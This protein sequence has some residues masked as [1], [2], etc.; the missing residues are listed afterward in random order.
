MTLHYE[1]EPSDPRVQ[2]ALTLVVDEFGNVLKSAAIGYGRRRNS[3]DPAFTDED[4]AKQRLIH[5]TATE[6]TYTNAI[7]DTDGNYRTPLP[8]ESATYELRKPEQERSPDGLTELYRFEDVLARV[9]QAGDG[10]HEVDYEERRVP[11]A[12]E[13]IV[14]WPGRRHHVSRSVLQDRPDEAWQR[15]EL[16]LKPHLVIADSEHLSHR[17]QGAD[18]VV[19]LRDGTA[20]FRQAVGVVDDE[21]LEGCQSPALHVHDE[22]APRAARL[23]VGDRQA[24]L[25]PVEDIRGEVADLDGPVDIRG[26]GRLPFPVVVLAPGEDGLD[27]H[28][29][30]LLCPGLGVPLE[31]AE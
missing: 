12:L 2:H 29:R 28:L 6:A 31:G 24:Q 10:N 3:T 18:R 27:R 17:V 7:D 30:H 8:A 19:G 4:R 9:V 15:I 22:R 11:G 20:L 14:Q 26:P 21:A 16:I 1:R 25:R 23:L 13:V 5:I